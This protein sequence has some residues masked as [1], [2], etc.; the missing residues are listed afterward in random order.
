MAKDIGIDLGTA[1]VLIYVAGKGIVLNEP[2]VVAVDTR[3]GKVLAVGSEA[4]RMV[5]RTPS[6]IRAIRP[7]KDGVISDFDIT[8]EMLT[9]FINK[10]DVKGFMS[11]PKIMICAPT[12]VTEIER[13]AI[14]QAAEKAGGGQVYLEEEPK[15]AAVGAGMDIFQPRG[16]MVIDMGGGTSDIAIISLGDIVASKS[17]RVAG[18]KMNTEIA[19]YIK[20]KHNLIIGEHTAEK[21]KIEIGTAKKDDSDVKT[22]EVRGRDAVSGMPRA[23]TIDSN[24]IAEAINDT[25][26][27]IIS[28]AKEVLEVIPPELASD[29]VDRGIMLTGGGALL[30]NIDQVIADALTVPVIIS[31]NPLDNVAKGAGILLEHYIKNPKLKA[32]DQK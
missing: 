2:S 17:I 24:E 31:E 12:N 18:D 1:N 29:I 5:G 20:Q 28:G 8:E 4:Y 10:L 11:K 13:N 32:K 26:Q 23:V 14:M 15:V 7:L 30:R 6:N 3:T 27:L 9:Y 25:V 16:N 19:S 21:I 22:L